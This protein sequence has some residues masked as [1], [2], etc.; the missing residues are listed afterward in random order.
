MCIVAVSVGNKLYNPEKNHLA[1]KMINSWEKKWV[2]AALDG[3][4]C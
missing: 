3:K 1:G 4:I 2:H